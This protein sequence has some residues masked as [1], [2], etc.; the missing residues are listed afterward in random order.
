[1][2]RIEVLSDEVFV[3][4]SEKNGRSF[5]FHKQDVFVHLGEKYPLRARIRIEPGKSYAP[6]VYTLDPSSFW[7]D[8]YGELRLTPRLVPVRPVEKA[9][10]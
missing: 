6:G 3:Y 10:A 2:V 8:R 5:E 9:V 4:R 1:M 7:V